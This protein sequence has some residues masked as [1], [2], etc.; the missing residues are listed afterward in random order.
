MKAKMTR[1]EIKEAVLKFVSEVDYDIY[2]EM[3]FPDDPEYMEPQVNHLVNY[4]IKLFE[5]NIEETEEG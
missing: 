5:I 3:K 4:A 2:K 1:E